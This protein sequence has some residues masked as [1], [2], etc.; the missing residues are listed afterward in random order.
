MQ[1]KTTIATTIEAGCRRAAPAAGPDAGESRVPRFWASIR[2]ECR[3]A[4][5]SGLGASFKPSLK[6]SLKPGSLDGSDPSSLLQRTHAWES[7][8]S[9]FWD[10]NLPQSLDSPARPVG[11]DAAESRVSCF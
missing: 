3:V 11:P 10:L 2:P 7:S 4:G 5:R 1:I 6:P 8:A 9:R